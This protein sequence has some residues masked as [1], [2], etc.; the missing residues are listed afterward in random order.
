[1][2]VMNPNTEEFVARHVPWF[3]PAWR[4]LD[5]FVMRLD[6]ARY[7]WLYVHGGVYADLDVQATND[8]TPWLLDADVVLPSSYGSHEKLKGCWRHTRYH[9]RTQGRCGVH[10]GNWWMASKPG[11]PLWLE[12]LTYVSDNVD[13]Y[14]NA[15]KRRDEVSALGHL[16]VD[17]AC[18]TRKSASFAF[19]EAAAQPHCFGSILFPCAELGC[20]QLEEVA[21]GH[22]LQQGS[23]RVGMKATRL[24]KALTDTACGVR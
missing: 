16:R 19:A 5:E 20:R 15:R 12:M 2:G 21:S 7:M 6:V 8:M 14:C 1:M 23:G 24:V 4:R 17:W 10:V 18:R 13:V 11:H 3:L 9:H 22:P